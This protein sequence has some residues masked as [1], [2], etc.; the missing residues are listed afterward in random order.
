[1][2]AK[3][4]DVVRFIN[5]VGGGTVTR[6]QDKL[7]YVLGDDGFEIPVLNNEVVVIEK[8]K[9]DFFEK[10]IK[11][12]A[13]VKPKIEPE[14][15]EEDFSPLQTSD[16]IEDELVLNNELFLS[17]NKKLGLNNNYEIYLI[18][19]GNYYCLYQIGYLVKNTYTYL[20][21]GRLEPDTQVLVA[22]I[23]NYESENIDTISAQ[24]IYSHPNAIVFNSVCDRK[25]QIKGRMNQIGLFLQNDYFDDPAW[26]INLL[27]ENPLKESKKA[28]SINEVVE[29]KETPI[30]DNSK[31]FKKRPK[32]VTVEIDLHIE[33]LLDDFKGMSNHEIVTYQL[34]IF[35][36]ELEKAMREKVHRIVFI[37]GIGNGTLKL[38]LRKQLDDLYPF[39]NFQDASFA[40]YGFGAT[41]VLLDRIR[42]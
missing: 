12:D 38:Q 7:V 11:K 41:M 24:V 10:E 37:H 17:I 5:E 2:T 40:E 21:A 3:K 30:V 19:T 6:I 20:D 32:P 23:D 9:K 18:N 39:L 25:I 22:E 14:K 35:R 16:L 34:E 42:K 29:I 27:E 4:G 36:K 1:M 26:I 28:I 33:K 8:A 31:K 13:Y 15:I